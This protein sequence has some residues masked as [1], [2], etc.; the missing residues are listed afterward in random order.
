M[1]NCLRFVC[2][3]VWGE[4]SSSKTTLTIDRRLLLLCSLVAIF[5]L[6]QLCR[7][8][9]GVEATV[10][11]DTFFSKSWP[12]AGGRVRLRHF[13]WWGLKRVEYIAESQ[14][15]TD[16][17]DPDKKRQKRWMII[18]S[19]APKSEVSGRQEFPWPLFYVNNDL[20]TYYAFDGR[21]MKWFN[22]QQAEAN[23]APEQ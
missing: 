13:E 23:P 4:Q 20:F 22:F 17:D 3:G 6:I 19:T 9:D 2:H 7:G 8:F 18:N 15:Y 11:S 5:G 12:N 1:V 21:D 14:F 16:E 10:V